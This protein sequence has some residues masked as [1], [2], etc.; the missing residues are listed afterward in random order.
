MNLS[1][2][3]VVRSSLQCNNFTF[4]F[5]I[6]NC[7]LVFKNKMHSIWKKDLFKKVP[8]N[9]QS[10]GF[11]LHEVRSHCGPWVF[12]VVCYCSFLIQFTQLLNCFQTGSVLGNLINKGSDMHRYV[13]KYVMWSHSITLFSSLVFSIFSQE[14]NHAELCDGHD[15][16]FLGVTQILV[17]LLTVGKILCGSV[18]SIVEQIY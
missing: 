12:V 13:E 16:V 4:S 8:K 6:Q 9:S 1:V 7:M 3:L 10:A 14:H 2:W 11:F 17:Q 5:I 18:S 15:E